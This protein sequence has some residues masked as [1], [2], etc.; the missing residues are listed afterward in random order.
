[1]WPL[2]GHV[3]NYSL[4]DST[5]DLPHPPTIPANTLSHMGTTL[6]SITTPHP[7]IF[8]LV[9]LDFTTQGTLPIPEPARK[10]AVGLQLKDLVH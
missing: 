5:S 2:A 10:W 6:Y 7:D 4:G 8:K 9:H 3:Q 1:M